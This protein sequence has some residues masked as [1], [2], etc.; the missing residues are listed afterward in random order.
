M[1]VTD[2]SDN[3]SFRLCFLFKCWDHPAQNG[4]N[5]IAWTSFRY[6]PVKAHHFLYLLNLREI[7]IPTPQPD[8]HLPDHNHHRTCMDLSSW[9]ETILDSRDFSTSGTQRNPLRLIS[10]RSYHRSSQIITDPKFHHYFI[11]ISDISSPHIPPM[12]WSGDIS[13]RKHKLDRSQLRHSPRQTASVPDPGK[14]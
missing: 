10:S 7:A 5:C 1:I 4:S 2:S 9:T 8:L 11:Y 3:L 14:L 13:L 12:I 6:V